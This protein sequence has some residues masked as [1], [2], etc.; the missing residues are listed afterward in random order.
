MNWVLYNCAHQNSTIKSSDGEAWIRVLGF[1]V[2][3]H[4]AMG[5]AKRLNFLDQGLEIRI[6]PVGEFRVMLRD[7][8]LPSNRSREVAKHTFL[9]EAHANNR[10]TAFEETLTN[11]L[12]RR[13]GDLNFTPNE[14]AV[15]HAEEFNIRPETPPKTP[16]NIPNVK[17]INADNVI[18]MQRFAAIAIIPDYEHISNAQSSLMQWETS[19]DSEYTRLKNQVVSENLK[20]RAIPSL[21]DLTSQW[22]ERYPPPK[23]LNCFGQMSDDIWTRN[24]LS[25]STD[26]EFVSWQKNLHLEADRCLWAFLGIEKPDRPL[27]LKDWIKQHPI[28]SHFAGSEPAVAFLHCSDTETEMKEWISLS[29]LKDVDIA[30]VA[31]Y[32]WI[33]LNQAWSEKVSKL[34]REPM[35]SHIHSNKALQTAEAARIEGSVKE[36]VVTN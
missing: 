8:C 12:E 13:M 9:I 1:F 28:P 18:R 30:C 35:I 16:E 36:I 2:A 11:A 6:A 5:H 21:K 29:K 14:R 15:A 33:K 31:M 3:K 4:E 19:R 20:D 34:Y 23:S 24:D 27:I 22:V 25:V 7:K 32:E 10:K 26:T 17:S